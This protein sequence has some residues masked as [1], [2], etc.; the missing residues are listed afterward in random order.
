M[1]DLSH[2]PDSADVELL[3]R[4]NSY[5]PTDAIKQAIAREQASI[6]ALAAAGEWEA[7][8]GWG[9]FL[10]G[11]APE[12]REFEEINH[13][14]ELDLE[15]GLVELRSLR[16]YGQAV[17]LGTVRQMKAGVGGAGVRVTH[18]LKL[19]YRG[20]GFRGYSG[21][22]T[23]VEVT[24]I[25]GCVESVPADVWQQVLQRAA[26]T[27][28]Q[29]IENLQSIGSI[30]QAGFSKSYDVVGII[31]QKDLQGIWEKGFDT[32]ARLWQRVCV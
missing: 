21:S 20:Y 18:R 2:W 14:G 5:W 16:I 6:G 22:V 31:S 4:S 10:A 9:P 11:P 28:L 17:D 29:Q 3:L 24:G 19:G 1:P 26:L 13:N 15:G 23:P 30:S 7:R 32:Y 27:A 25:W 8:V 12:T